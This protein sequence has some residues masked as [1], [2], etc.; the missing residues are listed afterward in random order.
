MTRRQTSPLVVA[1]VIVLGLIAPLM[2]TTIVNVAIPSLRS[3]L[4]ATVSTIQWVSTGYLLAMAVAIPV[5]GWASQ[6]WGARRMWLAGLWLFLIGSVLAGLA[7]NT[8]SLIGFRALQGVAAGL[9]IPIMQTLLI[10]GGAAGGPGGGAPMRNM[11]ALISLPALLGPVFG[12]VI[13]GLIVNHMS[14]RW[15]FYV[16]PPI[17]LVAIALA[18]VF[19]PRDAGIRTHRLDLVG[20][21]LLSPAVAGIVYGL[22]ELGNRGGVAHAAVLLP[23][24]G[25][26]VLLGAFLWH[27]LR[28]AEPLVDLRLFKV[29]TFSAAG[30]LLFLTGMASFGA[31]LLL[32]LYYQQLRGDS[33]VVAGLLM[34][35]QG[36]GIALSRGVA[37]V[38]ERWGARTVVL[39]AV[40]L[41]IA[42]TLPFAFAG[43]DT[44]PVLLAAAL[45]VRGA[46]LGTVMMAVLFGAYEGL[47][48]PQIPHASTTT[49]ILQQLGGSFGTA[50]LAVLLQRGLAAH[51]AD[52]AVAFD[53]A[54]AWSIALSLPALVAA[55][56]VP[57][58][59]RPGDA[60]P[61]S[62]RTR[63]G[64]RP[65]DGPAVEDGHSGDR[66][67]PMSDQPVVADR[68]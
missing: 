62:D 16:N 50:V 14:W 18:M 34:M 32:P 2:D 47:A 27:A 65:T 8:G 44:S 5:T 9:L 53:H 13:G 17:C 61:E 1:L 23:L 42:G 26:A 57:G 30:A 36:I 58:R 33:V 24:V 25:G 60:G 11:M 21:L 52:P 49:R 38:A 22:S 3:D 40:L 20:L 55:F 28:T 15:I 41:S 35:P 7:W 66:S 19:L 46:G 67:D 54:F 56:F 31:L 68:R 45:V 51:A 63:V 4:D 37:G 59:K 48:K 6:R 10:G 12:P 29:R 43:P 39:T 64:G